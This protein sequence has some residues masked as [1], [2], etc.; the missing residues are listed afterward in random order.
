MS[1]LY[2]GVLFDDWE[3]EEEGCWSQICSECLK[4]HPKLKATTSECGGPG[5]MCAVAGCDNE[6]G[7]YIDFKEDD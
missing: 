2:K 4:K 7:Y 1:Y 5:L 6:A 3:E